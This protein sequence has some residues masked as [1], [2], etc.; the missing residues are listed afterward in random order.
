V[1]KTI[2]VLEDE[3]HLLE[4]LE[5]LLTLEGYRVSQ[6]TSAAELLSSLHAQMPNAVLIDVNLKGANGL[7]LLRKIRAD[8][9]LKRLV[10]LLSSG[11]DYR[12]EALDQGADGF[13]QKPYM[14]DDLVDALKQK[15]GE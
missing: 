12:Q 13:L 7:D 9:A 15:V 10:V 8:E 11:T 1:S 2:M 6:P 5:S 4:L 3:P 14:P